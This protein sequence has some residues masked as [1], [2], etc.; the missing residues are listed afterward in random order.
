MRT[1]DLL[2]LLL[3]PL[4]TITIV[5]CNTTRN[6]TASSFKKETTITDSKAN[7]VADLDDIKAIFKNNAPYTYN[8]GLILNKSGETIAYCSNGYIL[9]KN[10]KTLGYYSNGYI[11]DSN[12]KTIGNYANGYITLKKNSSTVPIT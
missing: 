4:C 7:K 1:K 11:L 9:D 10:K 3:F 12:Y 2:L 6:Q 5:C 8:N